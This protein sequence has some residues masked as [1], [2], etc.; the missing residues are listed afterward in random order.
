LDVTARNLADAWREQGRATI[1]DNRAGA[2]GRIA[3]GQL[4]REKADGSVLLCTHTSAM[5]I[6]PSVYAK[7]GYDPVADF[8]PVSSLV[9]A[10]C[11]FAVSKVVPDSV[12]TLTDYVR[13][14]KANPQLAMFASP[15]AGSAAHFL[16]FRFDQSAGLKLSHVPYKGSAPAMQDL[17]GAQIAAYMGFVADF[18]QYAGND[19]LRILGVTGDKR[20]RFM[21][22]VPTFAEQG[23]PDVVG[24]ESYGLFLPPG[25]SDAVTA[26]LGDAARRAASSPALVAS[27]DKLGLEVV[28]STPAAY[29]Q[30]IAQERERWTPIVVASGF[31]I[32]D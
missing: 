12:K 19:K 6:Y 20:S 23:F 11:A 15:A 10:T 5:T 27:F 26:E 22:G 13:W 9:N 31:R 18:M 14:V 17:L 30:R 29:V 3:S 16:G 28:S 7:L 8:K 1:V 32:E 25:A 2:A 4:K 21:P 24:S